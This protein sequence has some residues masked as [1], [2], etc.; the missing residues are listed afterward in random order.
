LL[1]RF[2]DW[3][4]AQSAWRRWAALFVELMELLRSHSERQV[5]E[6]DRAG[7]R[8]AEGLWCLSRRKAGHTR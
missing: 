2:E 1:K 6:R 4:N 8:W 7:Q 5:K 3:N